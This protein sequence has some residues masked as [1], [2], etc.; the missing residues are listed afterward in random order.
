MIRNTSN[1]L[2]RLFD[3]QKSQMSDEEFEWFA[4][5]DDFIACQADNMGCTLSLLSMILAGNKQDH[6]AA[7]DL[8][9]ILYA[10]ASQ[11]ETISALTYINSEAAYQSG[12]RKNPNETLILRAIEAFDAEGLDISPRGLSKLNATTTQMTVDE[13]IR[14]ISPRD[15]DVGISDI[16]IQRLRDHLING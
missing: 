4:G 13:V 7:I 8:S 16:Q 10:L 1:A 11:A 3:A 14:Q 6:P 15:Y 2:R 9:Y 12:E 5:F